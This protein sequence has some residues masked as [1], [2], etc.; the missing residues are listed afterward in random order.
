MASSSALAAGTPN[1]APDP[2]AI[3]RAVTF[4]SG[5]FVGKTIRAEISEIQSADSGR[6]CGALEPQPL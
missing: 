2:A 3:G 6:K 4:I 5:Q 1:P